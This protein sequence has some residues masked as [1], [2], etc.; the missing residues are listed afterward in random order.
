[1][2]YLLRVSFIGLNLYNRSKYLSPPLVDRDPSFSV[3]QGGWGAMEPKP[4]QAAGSILEQDFAFIPFGTH[5]LVRNIPKKTGK[6]ILETT[7]GDT[8]SIPRY[9]HG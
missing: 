5:F 8:T 9:I 3:Q 2:A 6:N 4:T 7:L 1:M